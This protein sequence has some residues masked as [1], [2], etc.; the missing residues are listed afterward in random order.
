MEIR[1][2]RARKTFREL[3]KRVGDMIPVWKD[4]R[5]WW[6]DD[7]MKR[8]WD[9]RGAAMEGARWA[10]Y[11]PAYL[12]WKRKNHG[13]KRML[14]L[15]GRLFNAARGGAGW[16]DTIRKKSLTMGV[17]V[18]DYAYW[19]QHRQK[20]PRFYFY[21]PKEDIPNRAYAYLIKITDERLEEADK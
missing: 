15:S 21:T 4:F 13:G 11:S 12:K 2:E 16:K 14:E 19:L 18:G 8:T 7:M 10:K 3:A 9:S 6:Q 1:S 17:N 20:N 5:Q